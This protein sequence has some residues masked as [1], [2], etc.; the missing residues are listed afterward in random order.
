MFRFAFT[1]FLYIGEFTYTT[2]E[3]TNPT[4]FIAIKFTRS[5][6]RFTED[7]NYLILRLKWGKTDTKHK[8]VS[9]I[10]VAIGNRAYLVAALYTLF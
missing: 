7:Y 9:I 4:T 3:A 6:I 10:I 8:G 2:K 1:A 5:N